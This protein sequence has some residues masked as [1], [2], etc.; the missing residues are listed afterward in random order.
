M[1]TLQVQRR[2]SGKEILSKR[3]F[4][5]EL[6]SEILAMAT[7]AQDSPSS[8]QGPR[9]STIIRAACVILKL[10]FLSNWL[11]AGRVVRSIAC[12]QGKPCKV[13]PRCKRV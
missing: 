11:K 12:L 4:R 2:L 5:N 9:R 7:F 10:I 6:A 13:G 8:R 3:I 1:K